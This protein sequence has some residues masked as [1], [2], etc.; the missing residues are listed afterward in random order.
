MGWGDTRP[1]SWLPARRCVVARRTV[2][3]ASE[4]VE[5]IR[6]GAD[7]E[8]AVELVKRAVLGASKE[9][10]E[11][12]AD[13]DKRGMGTTLTLLLW[14]GRKAA[15]AHVGD[16]RLYLLRGDRLHLLTSD[17][18]GAHEL[19]KVGALTEEE[20]RTS[21]MSHLLTRSVGTS[22]TVEVDT[23][24]FDVMPEDR[25]LLCSDGLTRYVF[26]RGELKSVLA[27][28]FDAIASTLVDRANAAGGKD[29]ISA[30]AVKVD[31]D[32]GDPGW[33]EVITRRSD[34]IANAF[35]YSR[36]RLRHVQRLLNRM[37]ERA[38]DPGEV[39]VEKGGAAR[40][41]VHRGR[42]HASGG[43]RPRARRR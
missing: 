29:N 12:A 8:P 40:P 10:Y 24:L 34:W 43:R 19:Y 23:L 3:E 4:L 15:L 31:K 22:A 1:D 2:H 42:R 39:V 28:E 20:A 17:H 7:P 27:G 18:T 41:H 13:A 35:D 5:A 30:V 32:A 33:A 9:V 6:K 26:E 11:L 38:L 14:L 36:P 25:F 16:S 37:S 21:P